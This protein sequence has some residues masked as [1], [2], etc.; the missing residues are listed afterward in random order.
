MAVVRFA[1]AHSP[2]MASQSEPCGSQPA[3][4]GAAPGTALEGGVSTPVSAYYAG[5]LVLVGSRAGAPDVTWAGMVHSLSPDALLLALPSQ[6]GSVWP[7]SDIHM[8]PDS[9][10]EQYL[11]IVLAFVPVGAIAPYD[12]E[13]LGPERVQAFWS[14]E[15]HVPFGLSSGDFGAPLW[16]S[17]DDLLSLASAPLPS[18]GAPPHP[19][20]DLGPP[21]P[22]PRAALVPET[23]SGLLPAGRGS[24]VAAGPL[25]MP[26]TA[27]G[28]GGGGRGSGTGRASTPRAPSLAAQVATM[29][30]AFQNQTRLLE[31]LLERN[32]RPRHPQLS[33]YQ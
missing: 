22:Q 5:Q 28:R 14:S 23:P 27:G 19:D 17:F 20:Q 4:S 32:S 6:A 8:C 21:A 10:G 9:L 31:Q 12:G 15:D 24:G 30:D 13:S 2:A 16:P 33:P 29:A 1:Q 26:P 11:D 7:G 3:A 18:G 25:G